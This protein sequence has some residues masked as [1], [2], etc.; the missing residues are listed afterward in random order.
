DKRLPN[1]RMQLCGRIVSSPEVLAVIAGQWHHAG[2]KETGYRLLKLAEVPIG[3]ISSEGLD[4]PRERLFGDVSIRHLS[5]GKFLLESSYLLVQRLDKRPKNIVEWV[6]WLRRGTICVLRRIWS[7]LSNGGSS[8][9]L[10]AEPLCQR[11]E[12]L[13]SLLLAHPIVLGDL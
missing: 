11:R 3:R 6:A 9:H 7:S 8:T 2:P 1:F 4:R 12:E 5:R 13:R 10:S